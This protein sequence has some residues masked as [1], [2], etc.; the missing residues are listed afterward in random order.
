MPID[1]MMSIYHRLVFAARLSLAFLPVV[2]VLHGFLWGQGDARAQQDVRTVQ[3]M[4]AAG[5]IRGEW[6]I[7]GNN[8]VITIVCDTVRRHE[9]PNLLCFGY[10]TVDDLPEYSK[11]D[12]VFWVQN[13]QPKGSRVVRDSA[14]NVEEYVFGFPLADFFWGQECRPGYRGNIDASSMEHLRHGKYPFK[15]A[16]LTIRLQGN[17]LQYESQWQGAS[18]P[19]KQVLFFDRQVRP[20]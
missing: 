5:A 10:L 3:N 15:T 2:A 1:V 20:R 14:G 18:G 16:S 7:A 19:Q 12:I 17:R 11:N 13:S 4:N 9:Y 6:K 8:S